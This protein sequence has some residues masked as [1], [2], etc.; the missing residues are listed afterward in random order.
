MSTV[1]PRKLN[2]RGSFDDFSEFD[3]ERLLSAD[4]SKTAWIIYGCLTAAIIVAYENMIRFTA[5][6]WAKDMYSHGYIVPLF[7]AY[8][9]TLASY[10]AAL[11][12]FR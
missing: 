5:T 2:P 3:D 11:I 4:E 6:F 8:L 10:W 7:A 1:A 12:V 9:L